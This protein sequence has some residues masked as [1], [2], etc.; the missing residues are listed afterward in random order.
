MGKQSCMTWYKYTTHVDW[1]TPKVTGEYFDDPA[2]P[3]RDTEAMARWTM[4][5]PWHTFPPLQGIRLMCQKSTFYRI[6]RRS[7]LDMS[8]SKG[9]IL[10]L[11]PRVNKS[12]VNVLR[13]ILRFTREL[14]KDLQLDW[15]S[16]IRTQ[17]INSSTNQKGYD[18]SE[19]TV[20]KLLARRIQIC[21]VY[22]CSGTILKVI[23]N[24]FQNNA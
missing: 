13:G 10:S 15:A 12:F 7:I 3:R 6:T 21:P 24:N 5:S 16:E 8:F 14:H 9:S 1:I 18:N 11:F 17:K 22:F 20:R 19:T 4:I 23:L 2:S